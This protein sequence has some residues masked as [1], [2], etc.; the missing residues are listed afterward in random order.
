MQRFEQP[1]K[2]CGAL[3]IGNAFRGGRHDDRL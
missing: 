2:R 3:A 1:R